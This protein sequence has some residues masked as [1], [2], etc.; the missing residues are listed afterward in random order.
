MAIITRL[1]NLA[2]SIVAAVDTDR[3]S[4]DR[5]ARWIENPAGNSGLPCLLRRQ[6]AGKHGQNGNSSSE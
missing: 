4:G 1:G 3:G 2:D 5:C 6:G